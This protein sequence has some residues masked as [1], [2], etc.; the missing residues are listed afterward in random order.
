MWRLNGERRRWVAEEGKGWR[1]SS[2]A[3][4]FFLVWVFFFAL[5]LSPG[6]LF[7]EWRR[8]FCAADNHKSGSYLHVI[9]KRPNSLMKIYIFFFKRIRPKPINP[10]SWALTSGKMSQMTDRQY[11]C[12]ILKSCI[13]FFF[14]K[15]WW[16]EGD[17]C[18]P[19][20]LKKLKINYNF[21]HV[22]GISIL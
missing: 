14:L 15:I 2:A 16:F 6:M 17:K 3:S 12:I 8:D 7:V 5:C 20:S 11:N 10:W 13:S 19:T 9:S 1:E 4:I 21:K 18:P 22:S